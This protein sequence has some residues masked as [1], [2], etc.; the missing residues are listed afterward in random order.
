MFVRGT[1]P[2]WFLSQDTSDVLNFCLHV[3]QQDGLHSPPF[4]G[5][6]DGDG[7]LRAVGMT[8]ETWQ[9]WFTD[10]I[11][12]QRDYERTI[13]QWAQEQHA[14]M[15]QSM[16]P[17]DK[18]IGQP[19]L[20]WSGNSA[21]RKPLQE[22]WEQHQQRI[23]ANRGLDKKILTTQI[24]QRETARRPINLWQELRPY[25]QR[26]PP[27]TVYYIHYVGGVDLVVSPDTVL[28]SDSGL[29]EASERSSLLRAA[30]VLADGGEHSWRRPVDALV[31]QQ[32]EQRIQQ[33]VAEA[34]QID[35][36]EDSDPIVAIAKTLRRAFLVEYA[37]KMNTLHITKQKVTE[38]QGLYCLTIQDQIGKT[39]TF[40]CYSMRN[41]AG[42]WKVQSYSGGP[43]ALPPVVYTVAR[44]LWRW[45]VT[46]NHP[47]FWFNG[48]SGLVYG[49]DGTQ[50]NGFRGSGE[51]S[52]SKV[53]RVRL[54][55]AHGELAEDTVEN[56]LVIFSNERQMEIPI[57]A[58]LYDSANK[59][60]W[61]QTVIEKYR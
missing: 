21:V 15:G 33:L 5:H 57:Y 25:H 31:E 45:A 23:T 11:K 22:L 27:L 49:A 39:H 50:K 47:Q 17:F 34:Q 13:H 43:V 60:V 61:R 24:M 42:L 1:T 10:V 18:R 53:V 7:S 59:M 58:E 48:G 8:A 38:K 52:D 55:D 6:P 29:D 4:D 51:V 16:P 28:L 54:L 20:A 32:R 46:R 14:D 2:S 37:W 40:T 26:I 30:A 12:I 56:G 3:L 35:Q 41:P 19:A 9:T 36:T 44:T